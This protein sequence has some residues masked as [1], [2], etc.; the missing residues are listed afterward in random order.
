[1]DPS[2]QQP[3]QEAVRQ[4]LESLP[5]STHSVVV[6]AMLSGVVMWLAGRHVLRMAF[7]LL[8]MAGGALAAHLLVPLVSTGIPVAAA[9]VIGAAF[10]GVVSFVAFRFAIAMWL[11]MIGA[12]LGAGVCI[13][14]G[15]ISMPKPAEE[16]LSL[17]EMFLSGVP[18]EGEAPADEIEG[19]GP[20]APEHLSP[21]EERAMERVR[22]F[23]GHLGDEASRMWLEIPGE[24]RLKLVS[25]TLLGLG[26]GGV[27]GF[28]AP[29]RSAAIL[30]A[31]IGS[32]VVMAS[33]LWLASAV[34]ID[35]PRLP[36]PVYVLVWIVLSAVGMKVQ[37]MGHKKP[38]DNDD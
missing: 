38:A 23:A 22:A 11:A 13:V 14:V 20:P 17:E 12:A 29:K 37:F 4:G 9:I 36:I 19:V 18:I 26:L 6:A 24:D 28:F 16:P 1:M 27:L 2:I 31:T 35:A 5:F 21:S 15:G 8:G 10:G 30:T 7:V 34:A 25:S 32:A 33:A 3:I